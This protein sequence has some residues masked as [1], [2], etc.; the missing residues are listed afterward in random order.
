MP[1]VGGTAPTYLI[2]LLLQRCLEC[3]QLHRRRQQLLPVLSQLA[4]LPLHPQARLVQLQ[5]GSIGTLRLRVQ[6]GPQ[7]L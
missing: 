6:D 7:V 4:L 1:A 3:S 5:L 2:Q